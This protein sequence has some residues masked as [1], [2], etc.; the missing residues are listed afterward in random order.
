[1]QKNSLKYP[2]EFIDDIFGEN[3]TLAKAIGSGK[4]LIVAD[5]NLIQRTPTLGT[6]IGAYLQ[7]HGLALA[8]SV[9]TSG[10]ERIKLDNF[11]SAG[12]IVQQAV[13]S[14][15]GSGDTILVIGGGSLLDVGGWVAAQLHGGV[16][17]IRVPTTPA[18]M[19]GVA[20]ADSAMLSATT[21]KDVLRVPSQ[22]AAVLIDPV[23]AETVLDGVWRA[24]IGEA[25]RLL[26]DKDAKWLARL[27]E[28]SPAY[29]KRDKE[30]FREI[31]THVVGLRQKKG[32]TDLGVL[33]GAELEP[34]SGWKLPYGYAVSIGLLIELVRGV[35]LGTS[36][37]ATL[38]SCHEILKT[39]GALDGLHHS[40]HILPP[41]VANF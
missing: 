14:G 35:T 34:K 19:M 6:R 3:E 20:F 11:Q 30:A 5:Y 40:K 4:V 9:V 24:G 23:F 16:R 18:A 39:C 31:L 36:K 22:P 38:D 26:A 7:R 37:Q 21:V 10:G 17:L 27:K 8:G 15:F 32:G 29:A 1:M 33:A 13:S 25:V 28:L 2:V 12:R 41:E